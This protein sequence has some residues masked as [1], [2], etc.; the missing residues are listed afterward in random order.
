MLKINKTR[1]KFSERYQVIIDRYNSGANEA[2]YYFEQLEKLLEELKE[3]QNRHTL[4]GLTEDELE[5]YDLLLIK[6]KKSNKEE[7]QKV[8][9]AT[10]NLYKKLSENRESLL[11]AD[12]YKDENTTLN[13]KKA[14]TDSLDADLPVS[15]DK[16]LFQSKINLL[17][18]VF[19]D[20]AVQGMRVA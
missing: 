20:K 8:K 6:G 17:M 9:L 7:T 5:I 4:V 3:E 16:E 12:W 18:S 10:K 19:A 13:L 2:E 1:R 15:Y 11:V 14:V